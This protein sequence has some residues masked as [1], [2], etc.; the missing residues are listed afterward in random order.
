MCVDGVLTVVRQMSAFNPH[1]EFGSSSTQL[2]L[3]DVNWFRFEISLEVEKNLPIIKI[4]T[5]F[6]VTSVW[7]MFNT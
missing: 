1:N 4:K 2:F 5:T 3:F 6:I 7:V